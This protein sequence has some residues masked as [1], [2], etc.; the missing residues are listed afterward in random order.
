[1]NKKFENYFTSLGFIVEGNN[2][3]GTLGNYESS[4]KV[5]MF[6]NKTPLMIHIAFYADGEAKRNIANQIRDLKIKYCVYETNAYGL[7]LGLNDPLTVGALIKKLPDILDNVLNVINSNNVLGK[8]YCPVSGEQ[9]EIDSKK[10]N[11]EWLKLTL[12]PAS[13]ESL[14]A[15]IAEENKDFVNAPNNYLLGTVGALIGAG[16]GVVSLII[17]FFMGFISALSAFIAILLGTVLYKK[18]GGKQD[19]IMI[20]I[21]SSVSVVS[22]LL[23]VFLLY[24][25]SANILALD[26]G[27]TTKGL[28]AFADMMSIPDFSGE[29]ISNLLMTLL[30]SI[31]GVIGQIITLVKS[32]RRASSIQ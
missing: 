23:G 20:V 28:K 25:F 15:I 22:M 1:M 27:F 10:Y 17:L 9:L 7:L 19:R 5:N 12:A 26:Y 11:V 16:V 24:L 4:V 31:L 30:F 21:V 2:A 32:T 13:V 6:D 3:Y 8:G 14:N 29:F 18:F